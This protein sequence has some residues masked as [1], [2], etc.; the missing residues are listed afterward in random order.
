MDEPHLCRETAKE[1]NIKK[2]GQNQED[3][4]VEGTHAKRHKT[5]AQDKDATDI[6]AEAALELVSLS[7]LKSICLKI[8]NDN[9]AGPKLKEEL[10]SSTQGILT[11]AMNEA[12]EERSAI[13]K[14]ANKAIGDLWDEAMFQ[15][16]HQC[17]IEDWPGELSALFPRI[18]SLHNLGSAV[19]GPEL[20][21]EALLHVADCCIHN[22]CDGD[23]KYYGEGEIECD[24][25]HDQ[26]DRF[27]SFICEAQRESGKVAWLKDGRKE[28]IWNL[29]EKP[30]QY[31]GGEGPY[32][33]RYQMT[34]KLLEQL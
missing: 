31:D 27:M 13:I 34:L 32:T 28:E 22:W 15:N 19:K 3:G 12:K 17:N 33:Y 18:D 21:W 10:L 14:A 2:R 29:Q 6:S 5:D 20:A 26:V 11:H 9:A 25:F 24:E 1:Q 16:H 30:A 23:L 8:L 7:T 4:D